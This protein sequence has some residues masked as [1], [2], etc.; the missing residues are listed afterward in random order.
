MK[1]GSVYHGAGRNTLTVDQPNNSRLLYGFFGCRDW[2]RAEENQ[3]VAN[4]WETVKDLP[5]PIL[6]A[7]DSALFGWVGR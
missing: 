7:C 4:P 6:G 3:Q 1:S 5:A 2:V